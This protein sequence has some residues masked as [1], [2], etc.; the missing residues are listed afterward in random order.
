M[1][2]VATMCLPTVSFLATVKGKHSCSGL[3]TARCDCEQ[4]ETSSQCSHFRVA[5]LG[6]R[7]H[8]SEAEESDA[9]GFFAL[10]LP[11]ALE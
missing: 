9:E 4:A 10:L 5:T 7:K 6:H 8:E 2:L 3:C 11:M 1:S